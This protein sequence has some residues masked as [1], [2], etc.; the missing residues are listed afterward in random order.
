MGV[1]GAGAAARVVVTAGVAGLLAGALSMAAGEYVSMRSQREMF[2]YQIALERDELDEYPEE[3]AEEL[4]LIYQARGMDLDAGA[5][6]DAR[7]RQAPRTRRSMR[8][9]ARSSGSIPT[10]SARRSARRCASFVAFCAGR[11][12]AAAAVPRRAGADLAGRRRGG[13]RRAD[14]VRR[15]R[16]LSLFTGRDAVRGGLRMVLIGGGAGALT[17]LIG[18]LIGGTRADQSRT[19]RRGPARGSKGSSCFICSKSSRARGLS[20]GSTILSTT[21]WS[22]GRGPGRPR[23]RSRSF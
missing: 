18:R 21:Y 11:R 2:E 14:A 23:P 1:A 10:I 4:A 6:R 22:P 12:P 9:R 5:R 15:R 16:A 7:A 3:E 17:W 19:R 13:D 20:G 8:S